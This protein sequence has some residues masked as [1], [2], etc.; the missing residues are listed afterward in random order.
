MQTIEQQKAHQVLLQA[1]MGF[2][3][4]DVTRIIDAGSIDNWVDEQVSIWKPSLFSQQTKIKES[5]PNKE[6]TDVHFNIG[7]TTLLLNHND[8]LRHRISYILTQLFVVSKNN[9]VLKNNNIR[10]AFA[11]YYDNLSSECFDNFRTLLKTMATSPMM[12]QY[13]TY[14]NND[15]AE[16][17]AAD[18]NFARELMQLF[19]IGPAK[20]DMYGN[21]VLG[22]DGRP[23]LS[24]TQDDIEQG[25]KVMT[26]WTLNSGDWERPMSEKVGAHNTRSKNILGYEFPEGASADEDLD[27]LLDILCTHDNLAPF[28]SKFFI[29]KMVTSN[30]SPKYIY[31]VASAFRNSDLDMVVLIKAILNDEEASYTR[32]DRTNGLIRDPLIT[33][34]HALRALNVTL[35]S[36]KEILPNAFSWSDRRFIL[37]GPSVFYHYQPDEAPN[38]ERFEGIAAPE[39]KLY[40]W[41]DVHHYYNQVSSLAVKLEHDGVDMYMNRPSLSTHFYDTENNEKLIEEINKHLFASNMSQES[42]DVVFDFLKSAPRRDG[43]FRALFIQLLMSPEFMTQG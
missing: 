39:F 33:L 17:V 15:Y 26:G 6:W 28:I 43:Y 41:D 19:T 29:Q 20:L 35:K 3:H 2:N 42:K 23:V 12:G 9:T 1:T 13:L 34:S 32:S 16:G 25:A 14:L 21:V 10:P 37:D 31:R 22:S 4:N 24:Y 7:Y 36:G 11:K 5:H 38:D 18:E 8:I 40:S 30:P 27:R